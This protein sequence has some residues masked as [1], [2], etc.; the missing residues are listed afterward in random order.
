[1]AQTKKLYLSLN[2]DFDFDLMAMEHDLDELGKQ[3]FPWAIVG[4]LNS[5]AFDAR[6]KLIKG[7]NED[8]DTPNYFTS[9]ALGEA[10]A[11]GRRR[12]QLLGGLRAGRA[13]R[14]SGFSGLRRHAPPSGRRAGQSQHHPALGMRSSKRLA[15]TMPRSRRRAHPLCC[16]RDGALR[17]YLPDNA[18]NVETPSSIAAITR[19]RRSPLKLLVITTL[20]ANHQEQ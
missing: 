10:R 5:I 7:L 15:W 18:L 17:R 19:P 1:M 20:L 8:L 2:F 13:G 12:W 6:R 9:G 4:F 16:A 14:V 11:P 3:V